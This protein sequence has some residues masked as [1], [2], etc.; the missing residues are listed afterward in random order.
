MILRDDGEYETEEDSED[1][2]MPSLE[3]VND[4]EPTSGRL[5]VVVKQA[6]NMQVKEEDEVQREN[7]FHTRYHIGDNIC[8]L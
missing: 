8:S 5:V 3:D 2:D 7:I 4:E 6:L 1:D